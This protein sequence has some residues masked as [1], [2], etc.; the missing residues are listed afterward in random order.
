MAD[1]DQPRQLLKAR[2]VHLEKLLY[3]SKIFQ[4]KSVLVYNES[5][6]SEIEKGSRKWGES[7]TDLEFLLKPLS[8]N[9][10]HNN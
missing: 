6:F 3:F 4:W 2:L 1:F 8:I 7:Y 5:V 10:N 9:N